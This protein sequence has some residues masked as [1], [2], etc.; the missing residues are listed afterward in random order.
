MYAD[1]NLKL[2]REIGN[3]RTWPIHC[4]IAATFW[5]AWAHQDSLHDLT[6]ALELG[7]KYN[8]PSLLR[9]RDQIALPWIDPNSRPPRR[10]CAM[11]ESGFGAGHGAL[12][13]AR[14]LSSP[15]SAI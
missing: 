3:P 2:A 11:S 13:E 8:D 6:E 9:G 7:R 15:A 10:R 12:A 4:A 14:A 1:E 5:G